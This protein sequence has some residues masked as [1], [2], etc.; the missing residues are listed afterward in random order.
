M[1]GHRN[2]A[3]VSGRSS[4]YIADAIFGEEAVA[5]AV[6]TCPDG[7]CVFVIAN[8]PVIDLMINAAR[9]ATQTHMDFSRFCALACQGWEPTPT[10]M[11][12]TAAKIAKRRMG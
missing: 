9:D 7:A 12:R 1:W 3:A 4:I 5:L 10:T 6:D 2:V 11:S 8:V